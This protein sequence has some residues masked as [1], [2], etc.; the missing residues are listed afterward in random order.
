MDINRDV[1]SIFLDLKK[2]FDTIDHNLL[3]AKLEYYNLSSNSIHLIKNYLENR[4]YYVKVE[5]ASSLKGDS[6]VG[7]PQGSVLLIHLK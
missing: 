1:V 5:T 7:V 6:S 2:A 3:I 4:L